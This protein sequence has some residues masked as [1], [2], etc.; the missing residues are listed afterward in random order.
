MKRKIFLLSVLIQ[1]VSRLAFSQ[2]GY[3]EGYILTSRGERISCF[4]NIDR[5]ESYPL[6]LEYRLEEDSEVIYASAISVKEFGIADHTKYIRSI[7]SPE[8]LYERID[9]SDLHDPGIKDNDYIFLR[10]IV[11]GMASVYSFDYK[12]EETFFYRIGEGSPEELVTLKNPESIEEKD[13]KVLYRDQL[14]FTL[15][16]PGIVQ[17]DVQYLKYDDGDMADLFTTYNQGMKSKSVSYMRLVKN[18]LFKLRVKAELR[19]SLLN[20]WGGGLNIDTLNLNNSFNA[21][22]SIESEIV[23]PW[24]NQRYS[25][26][27]ESS[28]HRYSSSK[29]STI[30]FTLADS[31]EENTIKVNYNTID[32]AF[33]FKAYL[34]KTYKNNLAVSGKVI[35]SLPFE[36]RWLKEDETL[37]SVP[38]ADIFPAASLSYEH[39]KMMIEAVYYFPID[40]I[41]AN[42]R[43]DSRFRSFSIA[44]GYNLF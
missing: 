31:G 29:L 14:A 3:Q 7:I 10:T 20:A 40:L 23:L 15:E 4:I 39:G 33:G 41:L 21:G 13:I 32:I 18:S 38:W 24:L 17:H 27:L 5:I 30:N 25:L 6:N 11:E 37:F 1:L 19:Y 43:W 12:N 28:F 34:L 26:L 36:S 44:L 22:F 2:Q 8:W 16:A 35:T 42:P 9:S